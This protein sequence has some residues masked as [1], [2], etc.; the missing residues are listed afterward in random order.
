M[1][2]RGKKT[3]SCGVICLKY[4]LFL[5]NILFWVSL[6]E[7]VN[8]IPKLLKPAWKH[9]WFTTQLP[10]NL[11]K[12]SLFAIFVLHFAQLTLIIGSK[13]IESV[14]SDLK[15]PVCKIE[16]TDAWLLEVLSRLHSGHI[17]GAMSS[18]LRIICCILDM[19]I[20]SE[21]CWWWYAVEACRRG[22]AG[23]G[24]VDSGGKE[25]LHQFVKLQLL[26]SLCVHP[27]DRWSRRDR[28][29][30]NW[31]LCHSKGDEKSFDRGKALQN[32]RKQFV[33]FIALFC[34]CK[35]CYNT[36]CLGL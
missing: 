9:M 19:S 5:F 31:M 16:C 30:D 23:S 36:V 1:E 4:V 14:H 35:A 15:G 17:L 10:I 7:I 21:L 27:D 3:D 33:L 28:D 32:T 18:L 25:R 8:K 29:R 24:S 12:Y 11:K 22:R 34:S 20:W 26:L 2:A 6:H 13:N